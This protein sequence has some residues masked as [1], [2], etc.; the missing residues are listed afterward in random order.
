MFQFTVLKGN[1][2]NRLCPQLDRNIVVRGLRNGDV[3]LLDLRL[4]PESRSIP[5]RSPSCVANVHALDQNR[6]VVAGL[7]SKVSPW[8][9]ELGTATSDLLYR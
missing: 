4:F 8:Y 9:L 3:S 5:I 6:V 2:P 1:L 7:Q